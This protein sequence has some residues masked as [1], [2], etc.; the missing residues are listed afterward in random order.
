[1]SKKIMKTLRENASY[2]LLLAIMPMM[3]ACEDPGVIA[4]E[5]NNKIKWSG[6]EEVPPGTVTDTKDVMD[7]GNWNLE[8]MSLS[9]N[10]GLL[11]LGLRNDS[12]PAEGILDAK[13][14]IY[15]IYRGVLLQEWNEA[16]FK[17]LIETN[18]NLSYPS[19]LVDFNPRNLAWMNNNELLVNIQPIIAG[20][21][22]DGL[23]EDVALVIQYTDTTLTQ[24]PDFYPRTDPSPITAPD[25]PQKTTFSSENQN[26]DILVAGSAINGLTGGIG[27]FEFVYLG[28]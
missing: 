18:A 22:I 4:F 1:M 5:H 3:L 11:A 28:N 25:H 27:Q 12:N 15:N 10:G 9:P 17:Q 16:M 7:L 21:G 24:G 26:G 20:T 8:F 2:L 6:L 13:V 14:M 19:Q 23:P